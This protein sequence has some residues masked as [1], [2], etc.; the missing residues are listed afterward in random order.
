MCRPLATGERH[1]GSYMSAAVATV[2]PISGVPDEYLKGLAQRVRMWRFRE[3]KSIFSMP[4]S[5]WDEVVAATRKYPLRLVSRETGVKRDDL[6]RRMGLPVSSE[7]VSATAA[8]ALEE[9]EA[10]FCEMPGVAA[11]LARQLAPTSEPAAPEQTAAPEQAPASTQAAA[12]HAAD[13]LPA[14]GGREEATVEFTAG[15]GAKL[16]VRLPLAGLNLN[17]LIQHF[18][19]GV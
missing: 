5:L 15:D 12:E 8:A 1:W 2:T 19:G 6:K 4:T 7:T 17:T 16:T 14:A 13:T 10:Q 3:G 18:R 9:E 11:A